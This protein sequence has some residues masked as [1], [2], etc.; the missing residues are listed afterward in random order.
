[1]YYY[2]K[3]VTQNYNEAVKG[4]RLAAVQ[5]NADAQSQLGVMNR[6]GKGVTQNYKVAAKWFRSAAVQGHVGAQFSLANMYASG[7]THEQFQ[8]AEKW[9]KMAADQGYFLAQCNLASMYWHGKGVP[10]DYKEAYIW[11][12]IASVEGNKNA[13]GWRNSV[14]AKLSPAQITAAQEQA[15]VRLKQI[16]ERQKR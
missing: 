9:Y 6:D 14:K 7:P 5:G 1:M 11:Y 8:E 3:G 4:Y 2:G 10:Q 13:E 12:S 15:K 16:E